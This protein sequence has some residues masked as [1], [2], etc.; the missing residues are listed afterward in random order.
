MDRRFS[1]IGIFL[2]LGLVSVE[3]Q[4]KKKP[5]VEFGKIQD[6]EIELAAVPDSVASG[7]KPAP[8]G[9]DAKTSQEGRWLRIDVHSPQR[10]R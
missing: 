8:T 9:A 10:K 7:G 4:E 6:L 3:A 2:A 1:L 5:N